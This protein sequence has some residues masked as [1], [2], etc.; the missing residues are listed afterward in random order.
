MQKQILTRICAIILV[1]GLLLVPFSVKA[2]QAGSEGEDA[3]FYVGS[4]LLSFL[5]FP[6]KLV[7]CVGTQL[8]TAPVYV[9]TYGVPGNHNGGTNGR[10]IGGVA[11]GACAGPW[12][13]THDQVKHDYQ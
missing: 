13:I 7:T 10:E 4:F 5:Y 9:G 1:L 2:Q 8:L 11:R 6:T 12:V 3:V